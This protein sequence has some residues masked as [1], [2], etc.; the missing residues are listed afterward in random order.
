MMQN[1]AEL[2]AKLHELR[3]KRDRLNR[4]ARSAIVSVQAQL[5]VARAREELDAAEERARAR[6]AQ[7]EAIING[8]EV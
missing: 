7:A 2:E 1:T 3:V 5:D 4:E 6:Q 8:E